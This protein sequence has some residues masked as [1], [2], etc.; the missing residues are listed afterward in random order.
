MVAVQASLHC[1]EVMPSVFN[2]QQDPISDTM[3]K[4]WNKT[5][6]GLEAKLFIEDLVDVDSSAAQG[7]LKSELK[8]TCLYRQPHLHKGLVEPT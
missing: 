4:S 5:K 3:L 1:L 8:M 6:T 2:L 7:R